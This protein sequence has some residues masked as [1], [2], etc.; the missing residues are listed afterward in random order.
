MT[1]L[2]VQK[3]V[4]QDGKPLPLSKFNWDEKSK[5]FS[6]K[7]CN[8]IIDFTSINKVTFNTGDCCIFRTGDNCDFNTTY[9][10]MFDTGNRCNFKTYSN[11][12]F[13]T[14][15]NCSFNTKENCTFNTGNNCIFITD[16][17]CIFN[18]NND[19]NFMTNENCIFKTSENCRFKTDEYCIIIRKDICEIIEVP[20]NKKIKL[21]EFGIKGYTSNHIITI[22][23]KEIELSEESYNNLKKQLL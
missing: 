5:I 19:C 7:E 17:N 16:S 11:C 15:D 14:G 8:L 22:D 13:D 2:D 9:Y 18:T 1:K 4:L 10:C 23:D 21:N 20:K 12:R 6:T 3:R